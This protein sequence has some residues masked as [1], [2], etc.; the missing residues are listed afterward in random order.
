MRKFSRYNILRPDPS[1]IF[2]KETCKPNKEQRLQNTPK[3]LISVV[4]GF[5]QPMEETADNIFTE[6]LT[7]HLTK[8]WPIELQ[9]AQ[10]LTVNDQN[11][12]LL[13]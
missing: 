2:I 10:Q 12:V 8:D 5:W 4:C 9:T 7:A 1:F 3:A 13:C 11:N 6:Y